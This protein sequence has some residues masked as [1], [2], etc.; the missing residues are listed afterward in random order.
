MKEGEYMNYKITKVNDL[1]VERFNEELKAYLKKKKL[2]G[3]KI[4]Q[5]KLCEIIDVSPQFISMLKSGERRL[6]SK[7]AEKF[8]KEFGI[9]DSDYLLGLTDVKKL[10]KE[11]YF[12]RVSMQMK[13]QALLGDYMTFLGY[14][15]E[16]WRSSDDGE[17]YYIIKTP[18]GEHKKLLFVDIERIADDICMKIRKELDKKL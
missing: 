14:E 9:Q 11:N 2:V 10:D 8:A 17:G 12:N 18:K 4:T 5:E 16:D 15:F 13:Q 3:E 7:M 6:T 1:S